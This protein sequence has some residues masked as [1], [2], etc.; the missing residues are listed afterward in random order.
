MPSRKLPSVEVLM[1]TKNGRKVPFDP[2]G[3]AH[4]ATCPNAEQFRRQS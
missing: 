2:E 3:H 4:F 1:T